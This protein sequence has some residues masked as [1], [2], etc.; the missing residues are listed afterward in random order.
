MIRRAIALTALGL[1]LS[2]C[3]GGARPAADRAAPRSAIVVVPQVMA[4]QGLGGVIGSPAAALTRR[5]GAP[6]IDL[7][8][9]D[10][11]KLQFAGPSCVLDI[12][13]YPLSAGAEPTATHVDARLRQG[14]AAVDQGACIRELETR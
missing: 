5:F 12:F 14:G 7:A 10:A 9:G 1:A 8:E 11:R 6:R 2:G 3:A 4:A 13:L